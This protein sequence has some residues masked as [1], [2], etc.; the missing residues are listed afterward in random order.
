MRYETVTVIVTSAVP[1]WT[2]VAWSAP[3]ADGDAPYQIGGWTGVE[4][5]L[6]VAT[7]VIAMP[8]AL[9][10][11]SAFARAWVIASVR[12][13]DWAAAGSETRNETPSRV[14]APAAREPSIASPTWSRL[15][16]VTSSPLKKV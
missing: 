4:T 6:I 8:A 1:G 11:A 15:R 12:A 3:P 2:G 10:S 5:S 7:P 13:R 9:A 16:T 14:V